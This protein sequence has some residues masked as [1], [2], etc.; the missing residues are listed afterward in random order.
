M[1]GGAS[2]GCPPLPSPSA[3]PPFGHLGRW[4]RA[5]LDLLE[6]GARLGETFEL[7]L[8]RRAVVG[9]GPDWNRTV[10]GDLDTFRSRGGLSGLTPY[11]SGGVVMT[12]APG[13][14]E[15]RNQLNPPMHARALERLRERLARTVDARLPVESF[16]AMAWSL[17]VVPALLNEA[18]FAGAFPEGL[19]THFLAPLHRPLPGPLVP[20][21]V[22]FARMRAAIARHMAA[23]PADALVT[24]LAALP[25]A[26]EE[27]RVSLAAGF[28]TTSH[29]LAWA[30]WHMASSLDGREPGMIAPLIKETQ[31]LY[32]AGW[33]GSRVNSRPFTFQGRTFPKGLLVFYSP[34]LTHRHPDLW[35]NP[36]RFDPSRFEARPPAWGYLPFA[37]GERTCLGMHLARM[38][39][40]VALEPFQGGRLR[41]GHGDPSPR[42]GL[43]IAP[44]GPLPLTW[45][46]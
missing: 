22:R 46:P 20:R 16:D 31:R 44:R 14:A 21:P 17:N 7:R 28:D 9:Y 29:T 33:L 25:G 41:A 19:L 26:V 38:M 5:P 1:T 32:P 37:A 42:T 13:H 30:L 18:Y 8:W 40:Q 4:G 12:D 39:L 36:D 11:L 27:V 45:T 24:D 35:P 10:L 3:Q 2:K 6:E 34:Y 15:R 23:A 43:T